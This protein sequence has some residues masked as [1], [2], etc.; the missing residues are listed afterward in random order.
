MPS[1]RRLNC[2]FRGFEIAYLAHHNDVRILAHQRADTAREIQA[3]AGLHLHLIEMR[4]HH[5]NWIF[6]RTYIHFRLS[7]LFE[8]SVERG[9]FSRTGGSGYQDDAVGVRYEV[10]PAFGFFFRETQFGKIT[11]Q[12]FRIENPHH[13]LFAEGSRHGG[14]PQFDFVAVRGEGLDA[15]ILRTALLHHIHAAQQF[16]AAGDGVIHRARNLIHQMQHAIDAEAHIGGLAP[17]LNM[18]VAGTLLERILQQPVHNAH[19]ALVVGIELP[20]APQRDQL[21][22]IGDTALQCAFLRAHRL[23][24]R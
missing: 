12:Y 9:G 8:R 5:F 1:Q 7:Q 20:H 4:H 17:R 14:K 10:I 21:L 6:Y 2:H 19:Y 13:Q 15:A 22:E 24:H 23:L 16:D 11:H 18:N 3:D